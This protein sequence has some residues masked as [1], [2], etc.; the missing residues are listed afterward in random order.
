MVLVM[1]WMVCAISCPTRLRLIIFL[2]SIGITV[3]AGIHLF[4]RPR[5]ELGEHFCRIV[6]LPS[7]GAQRAYRGSAIALAC[8]D[9]VLGFAALLLSTVPFWRAAERRSP[10]S[11]RAASLSTPPV[12]PAVLQAPGLPPVCP[13]GSA[14]NPYPY[15]GHWRCQRHGARLAPSLWPPPS[16]PRPTRQAGGFLYRENMPPPVHHAHITA[17]ISDPGQPRCCDVRIS[18]VPAHDR[19]YLRSPRD[20]RSVALPL[21]A[22]RATS[23][24]DKMQLAMLTAISKLRDA[25]NWQR[26]DSTGA[27]QNRAQGWCT[28][29]RWR[30]VPRTLRT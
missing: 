3:D 29:T 25:L 17:T 26:N 27:R 5:E 16:F 12:P 21:A 2:V 10:S 23:S 30:S 13:E 20:I 14:P 22:P 18:S 7:Y 19:A 4:P 1:A 15:Q 24:V 6:T 11:S 9:S 28:P 8:T